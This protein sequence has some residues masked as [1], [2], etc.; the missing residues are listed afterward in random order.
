MAQSHTTGSHP[1]EPRS[2][3]RASGGDAPP[4]AQV[5]ITPQRRAELE[6]GLN[7]TSN[8]GRHTIRSPAVGS[9]SHELAA[10]RA[11]SP[12]N[13][14]MLSFSEALYRPELVHIVPASQ[15]R[16]AEAISLGIFRRYLSRYPDS[17]LTETNAVAW[18]P[19]DMT[20]TF[21]SNIENDQNIWTVQPVVYDRTHMLGNR[22]LPRYIAATHEFMHVEETPRGA[23]QDWDRRPPGLE[24]LSELM[25][26][27]LTIIM[28]DEV[29][30]RV[31]GIQMSRVV[32]YGE[33]V[34]WGGHSVPLG[35]IANFYRSLIDRYGSVGNAVASQESLEF[36]RQGIIPPRMIVPSRAQ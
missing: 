20:R 29:Y 24:I 8:P 19:M 13:P 9:R 11:L 18:T 15:A 12:Q 31:N 36:M 33:H 27:L 7:Y 22:C 16:R 30:K 23:A 5:Q 17:G 4:P 2:Q 14:A 32:N 25:P 10:L 21:I 35:R 26:T 3:S 34:Q 6:A 28:V 1:P